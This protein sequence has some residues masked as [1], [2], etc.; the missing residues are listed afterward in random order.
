[1]KDWAATLIVPQSQGLTLMGNAKRKYRYIDADSDDEHDDYDDLDDEELSKTSKRLRTT[2]I[3]DTE[4]D[5]IH[6]RFYEDRTF[7]LPNDERTSS[8]TYH[9]SLGAPPSNFYQPSSSLTL[10]LATSSSHFVTL[11]KV[12]PNGH[13]E[14]HHLQNLHYKDS[15][16]WTTPD[17]FHYFHTAL[18]LHLQATGSTAIDHGIVK[19]F[20]LTTWNGS[21]IVTSL[22]NANLA[23]NLGLETDAGCPIVRLAFIISD[24][25]D[26]HPGLLSELERKTNFSRADPALK[27]WVVK[28]RLLQLSQM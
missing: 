12:L 14:E 17:A 22:L 20:V 18:S 25:F 2:S 16:V 7:L 28:S 21:P 5:E 27:A 1:M 9:A 26:S 4:L 6:N 10:D 11:Q 8:R 13:F 24:V 19:D 3:K 15:C 23:D